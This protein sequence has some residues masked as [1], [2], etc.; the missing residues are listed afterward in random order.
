MT[1][2]RHPDDSTLLSFV[3][4]GLPQALSAV[5]ASHVS[6][7]PHCRREVRLLET[8]GASLLDALPGAVLR[9]PAPILALR[10]L[11]ADIETPQRFSARPADADVPL[12]IA[13]LVGDHLA[14]IAWRRVTPGVYQHDIALPGASGGMLKLIRIE[15]GRVIPEHG[16]GGSELTLVLQ[17]AYHDSCGAFRAGDVADLDEGVDHQPVADAELGCICL[18][19]SETAPK[20]RGLLARMAQPFVKF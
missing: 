3:A 6:L 13:M 10:S 9:K 15:P 12:P 1:V 16:H 5:V 17:G 14:G 4:G 20:F 11:E 8:L 19:A 7:C 18:I 2:S